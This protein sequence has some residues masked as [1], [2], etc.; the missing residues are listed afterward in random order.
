MTS[1]CESSHEG[2]KKEPDRQDGTAPP[3]ARARVG[4]GLT[5]CGA[6]SA[7]LRWKGEFV[8][9]TAERTP[10]HLLEP[11]NSAQRWTASSVRIRHDLWV[12]GAG[13]D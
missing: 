9:L 1:V 13:G 3:G 6:A 8:V 10:R 7:R 5:P 2:P 4:R 11:G 12:R